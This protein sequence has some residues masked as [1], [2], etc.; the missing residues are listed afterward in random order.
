VLL[1]APL[2]PISVVMRPG[3]R[4]RLTS[5]STALPPRV[6]DTDCTVTR[7]SDIRKGPKYKG[8]MIY[9]SPA[10]KAESELKVQGLKFKSAGYARC[11]TAA[12]SAAP[13]GP[14]D[15]LLGE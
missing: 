5:D 12:A 15:P 7:G 14:N 10:L 3:A 1:P 11:H 13:H 9:F 2:G 4:V 8:A 6:T